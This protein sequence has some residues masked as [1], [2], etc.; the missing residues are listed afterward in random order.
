MLCPFL[1][2]G[3]RRWF[4]GW[5]FQWGWRRCWE[6]ERGRRRPFRYSGSADKKGGVGKAREEARNSLAKGPG[7]FQIYFVIPSDS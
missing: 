7:E 2:S 1:V 6:Y 5:K 4:A 3:W